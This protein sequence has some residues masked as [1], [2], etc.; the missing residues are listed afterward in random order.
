MSANFTYAGTLGTAGVGPETKTFDVASGA[1]ASITI[2]D[3]VVV[4]A[5]FA[6]KVA[7]TGMTSAGKYGLAVSTSTDTVGAAGTVDVMF[8]PVGLIVNGVAS[9]IATQSQLYTPFRMA[10]S[11][12][13][14][15]VDLTTPGVGT[16]WSSTPYVT[17]S[18]ACQV[19]LPW[20]V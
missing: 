4:T 11:A 18:T 1:A 15:T 8:T 19:I 12:G 20:A 2:G 7:N 14:Q 16:L 10:V 5:G 13:V 3:A 6:A 17:G 9:G